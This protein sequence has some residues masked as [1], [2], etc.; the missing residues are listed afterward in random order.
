MKCY[1]CEWIKSC[2]LSHKWKNG[3][4]ERVVLMGKRQQ[5]L[6]ICGSD[7]RK[8]FQVANI[9]DG[10]YHC[11]LFDTLM[12]NLAFHAEKYFCAIW[13]LNMLFQYWYTLVR[14]ISVRLHIE[15]THWVISR[16][17][18]ELRISV[19]IRNC[20]VKQPCWFSAFFCL[21]KSI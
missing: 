4:L 12:A 14:A 19:K 9:S 11:C 3:Q 20:A 13:F 15:S 7:N 5:C 18:G 10:W 8:C 17:E 2:K 21:S 6:K 16:S 1:Y